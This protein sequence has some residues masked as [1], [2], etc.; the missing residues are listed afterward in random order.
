MKVVVV[1][2]VLELEP[3]SP[4]LELTSNGRLFHVLRLLLDAILCHV[5]SRFKAPIRFCLLFFWFSFSIRHGTGLS[6]ETHS[7][8]AQQ[9][10]KAQE[11]L[12]LFLLVLIIRF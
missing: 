9:E 3:L 5:P 1:T 12:V 7:E 10:A 11:C 8:E 4:E 2:W 6:C